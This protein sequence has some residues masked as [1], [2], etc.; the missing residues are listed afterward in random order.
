MDLSI[1]IPAYNEEARLPATLDSILN[2]FK[3]DPR[4]LEI[5]VV[6]DGSTDNTSEITKTYDIPFLKTIKLPSNRGKGFAVRTGAL[7]SSGSLILF[8][9]ADG[10]SPIEELERLEQAI[11]SGADVA[12]GS[13]ALSSDETQIRTVW[14]R[15]LL[16][17]CFNMC[18]NFFLLPG[19]ADT[20]CG[21]K[22]FKRKSALFIFKLQKAERFSFD[23]EILYIARRIGLQ[24]AEVAINWNNVPGSKVN[25]LLDAAA[26]FVDIFRIRLQ[27]SF[28]SRRKYEEFLNRSR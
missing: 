26:M 2:Y 23:L 6:D 17:R 28:L 20:Q 22:I 12:I 1:I 3:D 11:S 21:F 16:G 4:K 14:Y 13:R 15:R 18:V 8:T 24:V 5:V 10:S 19:I 7:A 27:Y 25:L 9:D